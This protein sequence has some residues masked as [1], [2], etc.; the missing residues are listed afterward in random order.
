M[1]TLFEEWNKGEL[2]SYLIEITAEIL[3]KKDDLSDNGYVVDK[4]LDKTG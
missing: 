3:K 2:A 1:A 4:I